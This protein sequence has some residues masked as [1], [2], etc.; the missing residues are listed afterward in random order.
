MDLLFQYWKPILGILFTIAGFI[1]ALIKKKPI[2]DVLSYIYDF[3]LL[4][5]LKV[6]GE[7][8]TNEDLKGEIKLAR[9]IE[10]VCKS[11]NNVYPTLDTKRYLNTI[12]I[13]I[14]AILSTPQKKDK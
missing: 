5:V 12:T 4:A 13:C 9:A 3:C 8:K 2:S 1:I 6:E 11:L 7:S 10:Y 14:E